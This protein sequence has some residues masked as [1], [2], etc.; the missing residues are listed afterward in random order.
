VR[1]DIIDFLKDDALDTNNNYLRSAACIALGVAGDTTAI[2]EIAVLVTDKTGADYVAAAAAVGLGL[3]R[4]TD[5]AKT[6]RDALMLKRTWNDDARGYGALGLA[7]MGDTTRVDQLLEFSRSSLSARAERQLPVALSVIGDKRQVRTQLG[8]FG[9]SWKTH[10]RYKVANAA[11][12]LAWL[13]DQSAVEALVQRAT[14]HQDP[15][16]RAMAVVALGY[17]ASRERVNPLSRVFENMSHRNKFGNWD[18]MYY[19]A[20]IL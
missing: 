3:L 13:R 6:V 9:N 7:L 4:A 11:Y 2:P 18:V 16:V 1:S 19:I 12:G 10:E 14:R 15:G 8:W 17:C 5:H 20:H